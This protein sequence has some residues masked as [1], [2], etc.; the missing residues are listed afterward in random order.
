[1]AAAPIGARPTSAPSHKAGA[2]LLSKWAVV[3]VRA[4]VSANADIAVSAA[5][6]S[7][8]L[9]S[10]S[11][12]SA[13]SAKPCVSHRARRRRSILSVS[14]ALSGWMSDAIPAQPTGENDSKARAQW[15]TRQFEASGADGP[16]SIATE[17]TLG[18]L[19]AP[20]AD[21]SRM[22]ECTT[23][24]QRPS[25]ERLWTKRRPAEVGAKGSL[26]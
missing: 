9:T 5:S 21:W 13:A 11:C 24:A 14:A 3:E 10:P 22:S 8:K 6:G 16:T 19:C 12:T 7:R 17:M 2:A 25:Q 20:A 1:M 18:R 26:P 15:P 4:L 23:N